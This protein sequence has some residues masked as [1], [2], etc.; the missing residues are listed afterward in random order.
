MRLAAASTTGRRRELLDH[1]VG[2]HAA[3]AD[4]VC[5]DGEERAF[6]VIERRTECRDTRLE[7]FA[8]GV[9]ERLQG[10]DVRLLAVTP[11]PDARRTIPRKGYSVQLVVLPAGAPAPATAES[12]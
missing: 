9:A 3:I 6:P 4:I 2:T 5:N 7:T 12:P 11:Y 8:N 1:R 10:W